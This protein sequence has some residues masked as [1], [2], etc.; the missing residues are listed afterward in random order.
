MNRVKKKE[1]EFYEFF[2]TFANEVLG[3]T[4]AYADVVCRWPESKPRMAEVQ[5]RE[6]VCDTH[7]DALVNMLANSFVTP[8]DRTDISQIG[9]ALD[10]IA[11]LEEDLVARFELFGVESP[12]Q[13]AVDL[14]KLH[15]QMASKLVIVFEKLPGLKKDGTAREKIR[16]IRHLEAECDEIYRNGLAKVF[17]SDYEPVV[18]LRWTKLLDASERI[19]DAL[20]LVASYVR[21]VLIENG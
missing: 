11:D 10:D 5:E 18:L 20:N 17:S 19:S 1:N 21:I 15:M 12:L 16:E 2:N 4:E 8:F 14:A 7:T 6:D 13:E 3:C 9:F